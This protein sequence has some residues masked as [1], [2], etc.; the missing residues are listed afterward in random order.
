MLHR[1]SLLNAPEQVCA[2]LWYGVGCACGETFLQTEIR[3]GR[4]DNMKDISMYFY[5]SILTGTGGK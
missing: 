2:I 5:L 4:M 1:F 3:D